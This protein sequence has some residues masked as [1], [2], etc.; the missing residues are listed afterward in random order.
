MKQYLTLRNVLKCGALVLAIVA[1][2]MMFGNQLSYTLLGE[3]YEIAYND[4]LFGEGGA[5]ISFVGYLLIL[6]GGLV[7]GLLILLK[8][9]ENIK[10]YVTLGVAALI[11]LGAVFVFIEAAV[12]KTTIMGTEIADKLTAFPIVGGVL[13]ILAAAA[14]GASEF[15]PDMQLVK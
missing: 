10:K 3:K 2:C 14:L 6:I 12:F 5:I 11:I 7:G 15:V 9:S 13:G 1:F 4:A 8:T